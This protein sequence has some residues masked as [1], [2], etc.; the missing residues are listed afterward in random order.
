M[1]SSE[2]IHS[3]LTPGHADIRARRTN[4]VSKLIND[5]CQPPSVLSEFYKK[6]C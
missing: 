4:Y 2:N 1:G 5:I 3:P 6:C